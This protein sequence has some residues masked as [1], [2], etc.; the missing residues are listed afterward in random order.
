MKQY[1]TPKLELLS[2]AND[3]IAAS[4]LKDDFSTTWDAVGADIFDALS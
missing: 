1:K 4:E 3:V 2:I